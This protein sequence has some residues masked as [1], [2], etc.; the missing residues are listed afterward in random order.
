MREKILSESR[1]PQP[2]EA[3]GLGEFPSAQGANQ[4]VQTGVHTPSADQKGKLCGCA[5]G[6]AETAAEAG[7]APELGRLSK[8]AI[9]LPLL[10][11]RVYQMTLS[12]FIGQCCRFTPSCS[13]Y[14][15]EALKTHGFWYGTVL[16]VY[17]LLRCQPWCKGG[18][19]P[20][21]PRKKR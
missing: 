10:L 4:A 14:A 12:P 21:P 9:S 18:Y 7:S 3:I 1:S 19:D 5:E 11:I 17:R 15:A 20:V 8:V 13:K 2:G 6:N 16:T